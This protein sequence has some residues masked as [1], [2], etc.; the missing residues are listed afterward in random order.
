MDVSSSMRLIVATAMLMA[1]LHLFQGT[2][3]RV[4]LPLVL[5]VSLQIQNK[6]LPRDT[7]VGD[8]MCGTCHHEKLELFSNT[9]HHLTSRLASAKS[10]AGSFKPGENVLKTSTPGLSFRM[11]PKG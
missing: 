8:E 4:Q 9:A 5:E 11:E 7:Y 10:I 1:S 6:P 2:R 3:D